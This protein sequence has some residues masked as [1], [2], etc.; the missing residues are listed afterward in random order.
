LF[1]SNIELFESGIIFQVGCERGVMLMV[2][3]LASGLLTKMSAV[4]LRSQP[5]DARISSPLLL[6]DFI[7]V[8]RPILSVWSKCKPSSADYA[9]AETPWRRALAEAAPKGRRST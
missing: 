5:V 3:V 8:D 1:E 4:D 9:A 6:P 7:D 2:E